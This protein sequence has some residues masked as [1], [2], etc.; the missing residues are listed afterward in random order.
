MS[1]LCCYLCSYPCTLVL[2]YLC[3]LAAFSFFFPIATPAQVLL[4]NRDHLKQQAEAMTYVIWDMG[5]QPVFAYLQNLFYTNNSVSEEQEER[6]EEGWKGRV[7][8]A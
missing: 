3:A 8:D 7:E 4:R 2:S 1:P 5:G 6:R